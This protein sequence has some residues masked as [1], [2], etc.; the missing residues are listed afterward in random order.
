MDVI[1]PAQGC[2]TCLL[3]A[4][5]VQAQD[6]QIRQLQQQVA[7][8]QARLDQN[9]SNSHKPPSSDPP[10]SSKPSLKKPSGKR[11]G[12]QKG[13]P[14]HHR[15]RLPASRVNRTVDY[16][17]EQCRH[18]Q[19][20]LPQEASPND[21]PSSW[22]QVAELPPARAIVTEHLAHARTCPCCGRLTRAVIPAVVRAHVIGP[23]LAAM[24][25]YLSGR[26]HDG[27]RTVLEMVS[28]LFDV[29]L[30]LGSVAQYELHMSSAL[31]PAHA[32]TLSAVQKAAVKYVD[33]TGWKQAGKRRWLW[34][35][36]TAK[37][38]CFAV[39]RQHGWKGACQLLGKRG[40]KGIVCSDRHHAYSKL[41]V[42]RRQICWSHLRRDF[43]KWSQKS[44]QTRLL[45]ND[46]LLICQKLF[47]HWWDFRQ[48]QIDR[49]QL[50]KAIA[51]LRLR[52]TQ[53]LNWGLRCGDSK[54]ANFCRKVLKL[55]QAL[56]TFAR[57]E[58]V[59]PTNNHAER[60]LRPAVLWR[61][62]SFGAFSQAGCRFVERM[63]S[64]IQTLRLQGRK[65]LEFLTQTLQ[66]HRADQ[67]L[68]LLIAA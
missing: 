31:A 1:V 21:P 25:S 60:V 37:V 51:P 52:L 5:Q 53:V 42:R 61:K 50:Q 39:Q 68:P 32:Q 55:G 41:S 11:P 63:L 9:S 26:C 47:A 62:N 27:R 22:H 2:S 46:G 20:A 17:P 67:P 66:A 8:L 58:G 56:W 19:A 7:E 6:K 44:K 10:W 36:A 48:R 13:H 65:V 54:A 24:M 30:S 43:L 3:L 64:T 38:A 45:G 57:V 12:G 59:E 15:K 16:F 14:G 49:R 40:G 35:A 23:N 29:P 34:T 33:E 28:D 18:C 4:A